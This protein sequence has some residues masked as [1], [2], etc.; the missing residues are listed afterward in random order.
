MIGK[1]ALFEGIYHPGT[2]CFFFFFF[3]F[4]STTDLRPTGSIHRLSL[5]KID[6]S[7]AG[8]ESS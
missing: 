3:F 4:F 5:F 7:E 8:V 1:E 6:I 2:V